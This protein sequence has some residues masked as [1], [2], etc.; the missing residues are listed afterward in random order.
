MGGGAVRGDECVSN[1]ESIIKYLWL[2][3][4]SGMLKCLN[5]LQN[6]NSS[7]KSV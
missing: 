2:W 6:C 7:V 5:A 1:N 4:H 3:F